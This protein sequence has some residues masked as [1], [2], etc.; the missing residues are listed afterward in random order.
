MKRL[1]TA[2]VSSE[3]D[4]DEA[5]LEQ[6]LAVATAVRGWELRMVGVTAGPVGHEL[7]W[8]EAIRGEAEASAILVLPGEDVDL[9]IDADAL[10]AGRAGDAA[11]AGDRPPIIRVDL[12]RR[13]LDP[14]TALLHHVRGLGLDGVPF[15]VPS[16]VVAA[17]H[18][19]RRVTYGPGPDQYGE[20][21]GPGRGEGS[22]GAPLAVLIHGGFYRSRWQAGLM[23][24]LAVDIARRGWCSWNL[25]YR[26]PDLHGWTATLHDLRRGLDR[27]REIAGPS[28][29]PVVL[30]G[31]SAGGQLALQLA[32]ESAS[33]DAGRGADATVRLA[34]SLAGVVDLVAAHDRFLGEGAVG[35]ALGGSPSEVPEVY[36]RAS[37]QEFRGRSTPWLLVQGADDSSDLV[38]M[39]RR[40]SRMSALRHP[41]LLE[42]PGHHF[43]VIDPRT[44]IWEA[45]WAG[46][47]AALE[48]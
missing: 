27:A 25:E 38:E 12:G 44:P 21:R 32:E 2:I 34:V 19:A 20:W 9:D 23:D 17:E 8:A 37:P 46:M 6:V 1:L 40:L 24:D 41:E 28:G 43:S 39:N 26:R 30:V 36:A 33:A 15:V 31:H 47:T 35:I 18:P 13:D 14:S 22:G 29:G 10:W 45:T 48:R 5:R 4:V 7:S 11:V 3:L 42:A 16:A